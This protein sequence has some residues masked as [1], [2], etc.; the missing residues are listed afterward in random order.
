MRL[1]DA[2]HTGQPWRIH[3]LTP[4]FRLQDVWA[5]RA[6][7]GGPDDFPAAVAAIQASH[8][9]AAEPLP[10]RFLFAVRWKLGALFGWDDDAQGLAKRVR[11]LRTRLPRDLAEAPVGPDASAMPL[12]TIY[13]L[14]D[15]CA[16][17]LANRTV[18]AVMHL[19]W[20]PV[21]SGGH[22]LRMAVLVKP[23][24]LFGRLYMA[25]IAPFRHL[26]VYPSLTRRWERALRDA[27]VEGTRDVPW[28]VRALGSLPDAGYAD[29]F[30]LATRLDATPEQWARAM[31]GDVPSAAER[32]IWR[33]LLGLRLSRGRSPDT[34]AG[35]RI[36]DR[37]EGWIRLEAGSWFMSANLVV[38]TI[39]GRV[40]LVTLVRYDRTF[41]R[42][43]WPPLS[44]VHRRLAPRLLHEAAA[45][46]EASR[47]DTRR[48]SRRRA[49]HLVRHCGWP[50]SPRRLP[51]TDP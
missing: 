27:A 2:A 30:T 6:P 3:E 11:S 28:D 8:D 49:R 22:E 20:A 47:Q 17:E 33:G 32:L 23:N 13:E 16:R 21:A 12:T 40:S 48:A 25:A 36:T 10:V 34:V 35:W 44:A 14:D 37:G 43:M 5:F 4:D 18:H 29:M 46:T 50:G 51:R 45:R 15:E 9:T 42:L 38:R 24:G 7:A 19:G 1:P 31:F 26:V 41:G 39:D